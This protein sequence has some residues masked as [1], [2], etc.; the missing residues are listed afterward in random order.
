LPF[1]NDVTKERPVLILNRRENET[2]I[3]QFCRCVEKSDR[4]YST[5]LA[6]DPSPPPIWNTASQSISTKTT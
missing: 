4:S 1:T 3:V 5:I 6:A 2:K